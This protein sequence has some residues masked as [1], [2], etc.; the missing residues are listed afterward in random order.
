V[1]TKVE[2]ESE[3][4]ILKSDSFSESKLLASVLLDANRKFPD[5]VI[6]LGM[7]NRTI[8]PIITINKTI[9]NCGVKNFGDFFSTI[10]N[11]K[12]LVNGCRK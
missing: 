3:L 9:S 4:L 1:Q 5:E 11:H 7:A 10:K 2:F 8:A 6:E 12:L